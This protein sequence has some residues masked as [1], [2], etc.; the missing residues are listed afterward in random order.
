MVRKRAE[1]KLTHLDA[2]GRA[3]QV[4]VGSKPVTLRVAEARGFVRLGSAAFKAVKQGRVKKGDP[5]Q[6]A[7]LAG[8]QA[9]KR[10]A[11]LIPLCHSVPL[12]QVDVTAELVDGGVRLGATARARYRTGVEMEALTAVSVAA[13]T[14]Y[15]M[16]KSVDRTMVIEDLRLVK[17]SGG[18]SGEFRLADP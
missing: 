6:V 10:T 15:D 4:D 11:E 14:V 9:A 3:R 18:K 5:L 8:I 17:K 16:L 13:L 1:P 2:T 12:T 7:R